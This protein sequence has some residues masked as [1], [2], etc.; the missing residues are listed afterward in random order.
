MN[1]LVST[2]SARLRKPPE[3]A[4]REAPDAASFIET[5]EDSGKGWFWEVDAGGQ[6]TYLSGSLAKEVQRSGGHA[7]GLRLTELTA[8]C[9]DH[10]AEGLGSERTL[11]FYLS[12]HLPF[13][14][15]TVRSAND[16]T[17]LWSL[18]GRPIISEAGEVLG[19]RGIGTDLSE[20]TKAEAE[21]R[22]AARYDPLTGLPNRAT[23]LKCREDA[24]R[25]YDGRKGA[26]LLVDFDRFKEVNDNQGH[27]VGDEVLRQASRRLEQIV[28]KQGTVGR[29]GG[30]EFE[31]VLAG[32]RKR[33]DLE[34]LAGKLIRY[35]SLPYKVGERRL[36]IGASIGIALAGSKGDDA[37]SLF[38]KADLALYSAKT[39]RGSARVFEPEMEMAAVNR[40][41]LEHDLR[42]ALAEG[43]LSL[44]FQ[45]VVV[46]TS[47]RLAGFE[48]LARWK[49]P[50]QGF[51]PPST[52]IEIAEDSGL[53]AD[54]GQW[55]LR[56][57]CAE[58]AK[59]PENLFV[60]VNVSPT[61]FMEEDF[62]RILVHALAETQ[63][64]AARLELEVTEGVF[65]ADNPTIDQT[66]ASL[67]RIGVRLA[68]DDFGTG[69]SSLAYLERAPFDKLK[70]DRS[71]VKGASLPGSRN[72]PI[73]ESIVDLAHRL[74]LQTTAE[75][76]ETHQ[77]LDLIRRLECS[78]VQGFIFGRPMPACEALE[79]A[80]K[81]APV[82]ADGVTFSR[83]PRHRLIKK[84]S[85]YVGGQTLPAIIRNVSAGGALIEIGRDLE[86]GTMAKLEMA[87]Y[88]LLEIEIRWSNGKRVG[89]QFVSEFD[90]RGLLSGTTIRSDIA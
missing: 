51:I 67:K 18:T 80:R 2:F 86:P 24:L 64:P 32:E 83:K 76:A 30:D 37:E 4:G 57:A 79:L 63:L 75:G 72:L 11:A 27:Q 54:L 15:L 36:S 41:T 55:V 59:W 3:Q 46:G 89:V 66:F 25:A 81:S 82:T 69:Y 56:A 53:I 40:Q 78:Y 49:H 26:I 23:I 33:E 12:R 45:P 73:L 14:D 8:D 85:I 65:L 48:A 1:Q 22:R 29:I 74:D 70:I 68:L 50:E 16:A 44:Y 42:V 87:D 39:K 5:F 17:L 58:A 35:V 88:N 34:D 7:S 19:F 61:Q 52:F 6:L 60:A 47:E 31:I 10:D 20:K 43:G 90:L 84:A 71:F 13:T 77:E 62:T 28:G 38:R 9:R 21:L